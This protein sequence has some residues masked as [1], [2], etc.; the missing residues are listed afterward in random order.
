MPAGPDLHLRADAPSALT[1]GIGVAE[2]V[3]D[4]LEA[5]PS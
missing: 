2:E 4:L 3:V 1:C 5:R